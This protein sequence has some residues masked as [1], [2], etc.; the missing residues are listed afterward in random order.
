MGTRLIASTN[1]ERFSMGT[2]LIAS[3]N[4]ERFSMGTRLIASLQR[5]VSDI[6]AGRHID[7]ASSAAACQLRDSQANACALQRAEEFGAFGFR[8]GLLQ[9]LLCAAA[10]SLGAG[11]VDLLG[12]FG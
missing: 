9:V 10:C 5:R 8:R 11:L 4:L 2:R 12:V 7:T 3:T 1:L 6:R